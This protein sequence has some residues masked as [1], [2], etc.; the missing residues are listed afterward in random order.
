VTSAPVE[1][2]KFFTAQAG[3]ITLQHDIS[4]TTTKIA[5]DALALMKTTTLGTK[6]QPVSQCIGIPAAQW[7]KA[8]SGSGGSGSGGSGGNSTPKPTPSSSAESI[9]NVKSSAFTIIVVFLTV[10]LF[11]Y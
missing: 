7:Y 8:E 5:I 6:P 3:F 4:T 1:I 9:S 2:A 10:R 11:L